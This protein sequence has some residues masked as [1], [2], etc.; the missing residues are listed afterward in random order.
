MSE[1][2]SG[3]LS[4]FKQNNAQGGHLT[5]WILASHSPYFYVPMKQTHQFFFVLL[6][7]RLLTSSA[8]SIPHLVYVKHKIQ[9]L[10]FLLLSSPSWPFFGMWEEGQG[11]HSAQGKNLPPPHRQHSRLGSNPDPCSCATMPPSTIKPGLL[12]LW[13]SN[14]RHWTTPSK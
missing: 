11:K 3:Y 14:L 10:L 6:S 9:S 7:Y 1:Y 12:K 4:Y 13:G 2:L 8:F 5:Q